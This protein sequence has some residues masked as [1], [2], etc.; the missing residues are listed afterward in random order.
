LGEKEPRYLSYLLRLW[1]TRNRGSLVWRASI[2]D[3]HTSVR[4]G[5]ADLAGLLAFLEREMAADNGDKT[6]DRTED[7]AEAE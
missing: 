4:R 6:P 7:A 1:Q 2:E 5:F 3:A